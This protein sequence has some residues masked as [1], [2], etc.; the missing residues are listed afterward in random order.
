MFLNKLSPLKHVFQVCEQLYNVSQRTRFI[1]TSFIYQKQ[2]ERRKTRQFIIAK[3]NLD[4]EGESAVNIDALI[5]NRED[6]FPTENTPNM[7]FNGI[8]FSKNYLFVNIKVYL[9]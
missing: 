5:Q 7:L 1:H 9:K 4:A 6:M 3:K 8:P 2:D